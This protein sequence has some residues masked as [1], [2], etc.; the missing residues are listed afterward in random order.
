MLWC[1]S[2]H[3]RFNSHTIVLLSLIQSWNLIL[4]IHVK[5]CHIVKDHR[6]PSSSHH[7]S[8]HYGVVAGETSLY[9]FVICQVGI[10]QKYCYV[11]VSILTS[12]VYCCTTFLVCLV[13]VWTVPYQ[14]FHWCWGALCT[15]LVKSCGT[16]MIYLEP[17]SRL[18]SL[19]LNEDIPPIPTS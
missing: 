6:Q 18:A 2:N 17:V 12:D 16:F 5:D 4:Q 19:R 11:L 15:S 13:D 10:D 3:L 9:L 14:L 7:Y 1:T 8:V